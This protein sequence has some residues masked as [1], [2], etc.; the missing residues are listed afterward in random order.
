VSPVNPSDT[1]ARMQLE[2]ERDVLLRSLDDLESE[3]ASGGI[4]EAS[5]QA[6][7]D[8]YTARAAAVIRA[9]RDGIDARP[10]PPPTSWARRVVVAAVIV[11][12]AIGAGVALAAAIGDRLPGETSSGNSPAANGSDRTAQTIRRRLEAVVA[13]NPDDVASRLQLAQ[14]LEQDDDLVAALQ[15]YDEIIAIDAMH[16]TAYAQSGRILYLGRRYDD[17]R[18]RLDTAVRLDPEYAD[19]RF[20]RAVVLAEQFLDF[21]GAQSDLQRYLIAEPN[22][23]YAEA[24]RQLLADVT[25][26]L[27]SPTTTTP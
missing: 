20:F 15:Q 1:D 16:A 4:D 3:R 7:H 11:V 17:A 24:A 21:S 23:L 8:D 27:E 10:A 13:A 25:A 2:A 18:A 19:A 12:F 9:L 22:G 26:A 5:Y 6:L 14:L